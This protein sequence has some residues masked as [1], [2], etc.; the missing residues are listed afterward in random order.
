[1]ADEVCNEFVKQFEQSF[2]HIKNKK[3]VLYGLG[4]RT[5]AVISQLS[6][7]YHFVGLMDKEKENIGKCFWGLKVLSEQ[8]VIKHA[9]IIII[10]S[11]SFYDVIY[12]RIAHLAKDYG[13]M[14]YYPNGEIAK[15]KED[16]CTPFSDL[17]KGLTIDKLKEKIS[18]YDII[19]FDL[20]DTLVMRRVDNPDTIFEILEKKFQNKY[21]VSN[22]KKLRKE[23]YL[24][25]KKNKI[26]TIDDIYS[27]IEN[28]MCISH[29]VTEQ[30]I[31][32]EIDV[33]KRTIV[34]RDDVKAMFEY[35][36][37]LG[38]EVFIVTDM[39]LDSNI[40]RSIL[41]ANNID[42]PL[43]RIIVSCE[44]QMDKESGRLW[45]WFTQKYGSN[46]Q[47]LHFGDD[48][49]NDI[50]NAKRYQI[51]AVQLL[52]AKDMLRHTVL[53]P[54]ITMELTTWNKV[55]L[56]QIM[57]RLFNSP[58]VGKRIEGN[59][60]IKI[61][62]PESLGFV[63]FGSM[64]FSYLMYILREA[65]QL[66][67]NKLLF[68][69]RDGF[70]LIQDF[71]FLK[72]LM[73]ID[74]I[75][76]KYLKISRQIVRRATLYDMQSVLDFAEI[77]Y[78]GT[79]HDYFK[80]RFGIDIVGDDE[81]EIPR[82][83]EYVG[84]IIEERIEEI[85]EQSN[86]LRD[87]Y[88]NYLDK[89]IGDMNREALVDFGYSGSSQFYFSKLLNKRMTGFY[90]LADMDQTN[91]Y[92]KNQ[93]KKTYIFDE[94]DLKGIN[95]LAYKLFLPI[96]SVFTAPY[97][98]YISCNKFGEFYCAEMTKNNELFSVKEHINN[99]IKLFIR[100]VYQILEDDLWLYDYTEQMG[101]EVLANMFGEGVEISKEILDS[102]YSDDLLKYK[103][104][105]KIF[106]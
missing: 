80:F 5:E 53:S 22:F 6:D 28:E 51:E 27:V 70:L 30:L 81:M 90:L 96:E 89:E 103:S 83:M 41:Q 71:D 102:F 56:G 13:M 86:I 17:Y 84:K 32:E 40:L 48:I 45:K 7:C 52:S 95:S 55:L 66:E 18:Q 73:H 49:Q 62:D 25:C 12:R 11:V 104:D 85:L 24:Q 57:E 4:Y 21:H 1:M 19:T 91:E 47:I 14:I 63:G 37:S 74:W 72:K 87:N 3:I 8:Q 23:A 105:R 69:A 100:S 36:I 98:T 58:F 15:E 50:T 79:I 42:F 92:N 9:E 68:C 20:F 26:P 31:K 97:G 34:V 75:E 43:E 88:Q 44:K 76:S 99:G 61:T 78:R 77:P 29:H 38:K 60:K 54:F 67:L 93:I 16:F 94:K 2:A 101:Q 33:E 46:Q 82:D 39:Y 64:I 35:A 59:G 106:E 10:I 65:K